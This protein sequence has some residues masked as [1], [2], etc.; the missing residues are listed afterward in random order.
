MRVFYRPILLRL[1]WRNILPS[2]SK[3]MRKI[4]Y[5]LWY[6][7]PPICINRFF[8]CINEFKN[9]KKIHIHQSEFQG[10]I[11]LNTKCL[12][13]FVLSL[14]GF[15]FLNLWNKQE[16]LINKTA[17]YWRP[18]YANSEFIPIASQLKYLFYLQRE[19]KNQ[20][21]GRS[22]KILKTSYWHSIEFFLMQR[23][24]VNGNECLREKY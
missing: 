10:N 16:K 8:F 17:I 24:I 11:S 5:I 23:G 14:K 7:S 18:T 6:S 3:A 4:L 9:W 20:R 2:P 1:R 15:L 21:K 12:E 22:N 13:I 19:K